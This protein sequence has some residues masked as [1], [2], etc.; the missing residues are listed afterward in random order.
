LSWIGLYQAHLHPALAL[1]FI[2]PFLP[3]PPRETMRIF[4]EDPGDRSALAS[5]EHEWKVP[6]D[7]GMF[8]FGLANAGVTFSSVGTATWLVL[9]A[10]LVG[11]TCG[12]SLFACLGEKL[13]FPLPRGIGRKELLLV[14]M[15]AGVG[16]TVALFVAGEAFSD[17]VAQGAAKMGAL[18]S[19]VGGAG[20]LILGRIFRVR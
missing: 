17:P 5:F 2:V 16:L 11:K 20:A 14:G 4:E 10:L 13:G 15:I 1:V 12:I 3:H 18:L 6:V 7:F 8:M 9:V 19:I